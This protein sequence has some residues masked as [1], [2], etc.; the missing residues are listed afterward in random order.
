MRR[1]HRYGASVSLFLRLHRRLSRGSRAHD[2]R[3]VGLRRG[4]ADISGLGIVVDNFSGEIVLRVATDANDGSNNFAG[5]IIGYKLQVSPAPAVATFNDVPTSD[6][7]F[8]YIEALVASGI[9]GGTGG[10]N[11]LRTPS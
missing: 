1:G 5:V 11:S 7:G 10:G 9:T 4:S 6:F 2:Q 3:D 8:Q